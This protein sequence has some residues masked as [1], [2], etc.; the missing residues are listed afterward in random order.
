ML[1]KA[2]AHASSKPARF[3]LQELVRPLSHYPLA[4]LSI[5]VVC[6]RVLLAS[7][8]QYSYSTASK[9]AWG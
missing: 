7:H 3:G 4:R 2:S 9:N 6:N 1:L 8:L 5:Q